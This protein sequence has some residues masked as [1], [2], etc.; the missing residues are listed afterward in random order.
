MIIKY[1][2][3]QTA[4]ILGVKVHTKVTI[5]QDR[6]GNMLKIVWIKNLIALHG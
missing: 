5:I 1:H 6:L 3:D 2:N 4:I